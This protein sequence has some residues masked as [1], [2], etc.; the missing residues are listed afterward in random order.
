MSFPLFDVTRLN[1]C[2]FIF[3]PV[4]FPPQ[5]VPDWFSTQW[6]YD[7]AV[8]M[9]SHWLPSESVPSVR[10]RGFYTLNRGPLR[11]I[12]L[13]NN[14]ANVDNFW[15]LY[16]STFLKEQLQWLHDTLL[17][18]EKAKEKVHIL[19]HIPLG[20]NGAFRFWMREYNRIIKRFALV[21]AAQFD[22][23]THRN[24]FNLFYDQSGE[25]AINSAFNGGS[26]TTNADV[27]PNYVVYYVDKQSFEVID[28]DLYYFNLTQANLD[29]LHDP[30]WTKLNSMKE[31][32]KISDL[33]PKSLNELF[34]RWQ[35]D[36]DALSQVRCF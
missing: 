13:N 31:Y 12:V 7:N 19:R 2:S 16:D 34:V 5:D 30:Q 8:A 15:L 27:N 4:S 18:A 23:H 26:L 1:L 9:W 10:K 21:I 3:I 29:T 22:G 33:S 17:L 24:E 20:R 35:R 6:L 36:E 32:W 11:I 14:E 28:L 25:F